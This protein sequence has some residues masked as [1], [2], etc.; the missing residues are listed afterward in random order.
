MALPST[1]DVILHRITGSPEFLLILPP[2]DGRSV[3]RLE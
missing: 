2:L 3:T 1:R